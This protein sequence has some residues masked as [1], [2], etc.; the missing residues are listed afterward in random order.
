MGLSTATLA[1]HRVLNARANIPAFGCWYADA[2][3]DGEHTLSGAVDLVIADL[4]L[5]GTVLS[6]GKDKGKSHF[7]IVAGKGGWGKT[8]PKKAYADDAGVKLSKVLGDAASEA[9]EVL[10]IST[11]ERVGPAFTRPEDPASR[12][13]EL[14]APSAW[15]VDETGVTRLGKRPT[16]AFKGKAAH[17]PV[18]HARGTVTLAP[19]SI[20]SL[21]P[22][23]TVDGLEA[24]DVMHEI[25]VKGGLRST[26]WGKMFSATSRRL[27]ALREIVLSLVPDLK[28]FG[29][30]EYRVVTRDGKRLN[31]QPVLVSMGMP[32]LRRVLVRPG[33]PGCEADTALGSRVLVGFVNRSP[34]RPYVA[35]FEDPEG[36]GFLP[37]KLVLDAEDTIEL[38][39]TGALA[40]A[41]P[42]T[43]WAGN[44][45]S[46][47]NGLGAPIAALTGVAT[48][49]IKGA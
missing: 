2:T 32:D 3:I 46:A 16:V 19:E 8:I 11:N 37:E 24:V 18:D 28:F 12:V 23:A 33:V 21:V 43:T 5:K 38:G 34:T 48:T 40:K 20:A 17:G 45:N 7:R 6:G 4:T 13:L 22:G 10:T 31:L 41:T 29:V 30:T 35:G 9:G 47:L 26:I 44:V 15:Y 36:D 14:L 1:G 27:S 49:K 39:G 42:L 25:S